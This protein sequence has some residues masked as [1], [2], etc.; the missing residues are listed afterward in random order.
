MCAV[1]A[2]HLCE[3]SLTDMLSSGYWASCV[4][5]WRWH[6]LGIPGQGAV[7]LLWHNPPSTG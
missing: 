4:L 6:M 1:C 3:N 7:S 2:V 5:I